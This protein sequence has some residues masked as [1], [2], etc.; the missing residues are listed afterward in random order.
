MKIYFK[1]IQDEFVSEDFIWRSGEIYITCSSMDPLQW[2]G[3]VGLRDQ[4]A[5]KNITIIHK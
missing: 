2:M 5:D 4:T 1:A 3:A